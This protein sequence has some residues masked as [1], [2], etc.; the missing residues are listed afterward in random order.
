MPTSTAATA[1]GLAA[2]VRTSAGCEGT[3]PWTSIAA[4]GS[5]SFKRAAPS[6]SSCAST[7]STTGFNA[8]NR[9]C[10]WC[11]LLKSSSRNTSSIAPASKKFVRKAATFVAERLTDPKLYA[12]ELKRAK[13]TN[14][15]MNENATSVVRS[16]SL[17]PSCPV[18]HVHGGIDSV[19][20]V[21][22]GDRW[23]P[24]PGRRE[25]I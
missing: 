19:W 2:V 23:I 14:T 22:G 17:T 1:Y 21:C 8:Q 6:Q 3:S 4:P 25:I 16:D 10:S 5:P 15:W 9:E 20:E 12:Y 11:S 13:S 24:L 7:G 18:E